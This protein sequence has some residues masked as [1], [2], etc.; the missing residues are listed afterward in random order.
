MHRR[1]VVKV[2]V[3]AAASA[4][5]GACTTQSAATPPTATK[6]TKPTKSTEKP[7]A[8]PSR[9]APAGN[10][11]LATRRLAL[12][13]GADRPLP[14][15]VWD[16]RAGGPYP[17]ILFSHGLGGAPRDYEDLITAWARA[18]FVVA[19]PAYPHTT[20]GSELNVL[21]IL[22]QPADAKEVITQTL[23]KLSSRIDARRVGAAGHSAGG[24]TTLGMFTSR[25]DRL[26]A[27][28]VLSGRQIV[29]SPYTGAAAPL[30]FVHGKR[31]PTIAYA[32]GRAAFEAVTWPK[33]LL[34]ITDGGHLPA[35]DELAVV[36]ET[37]ADF[38][39]WS[40]YGDRSARSRLGKDATRGGL[41]TLTDDL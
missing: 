39:R 41:A 14:T 26:R 11:T 16:P 31:D 2:L 8:A 32:D 29:V 18:G 3:S 21:D 5:H 4:A 25:D 17:L 19:A 12:S 40:L 13:R 1:T 33:A 23:A 27:G 38:W 10:L 7:T 9:T 22:N 6:S 24:I 34:T 28:V 35:G 30:L 15:T 37:S 36:A 20:R